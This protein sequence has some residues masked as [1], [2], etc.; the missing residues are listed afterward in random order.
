MG[1]QSR[2]FAVAAALLVWPPAGSPQN[3]P[4]AGEFV[5]P[6][7]FK[8]PPAQYRGQQM[9]GYGMFNLSTLSEER[10][11]SAI[12]NMAKQNMGGFAPEPGG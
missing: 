3:Q 5:D 7:L 2:L 1:I 10:I 9:F 4:P 8:A 11:I 6:A 12:Q